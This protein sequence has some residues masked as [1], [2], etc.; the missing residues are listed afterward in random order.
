MKQ[1]TLE[2]VAT[3]VLDRKYPYHR[4]TDA[5]YWKDMF[6]SGAKWQEERSYSEEDMLKFGKYLLELS[7][8][9]MSRK[10]NIGMLDLETGTKLTKDLFEQFK[11]K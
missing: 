4:P 7:N 9:V 8:S 11:K 3:K 5:G 6:I 10:F 1:E 2:E